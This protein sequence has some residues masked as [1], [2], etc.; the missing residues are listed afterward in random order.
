MDDDVLP[1]PTLP[2]GYST[3]AYGNDGDGDGGLEDLTHFQSEV[4]GSGRKDNGH[5]HTP[6]HAPRINFGIFPIRTHKRFIP[7][8]FAQLTK[9]I[10]WQL[11]L[12]LL[13][14]HTLY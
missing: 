5:H 1:Q 6:A 12:F 13:F 8:A 2:A 4:G 3:Q 11:H 14:F 7:L 10:L 9:G